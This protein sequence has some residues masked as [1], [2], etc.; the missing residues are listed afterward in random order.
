MER[1]LMVQHCSRKPLPMATK[2][3][4]L[5][6]ELDNLLTQYRKIELESL[7]EMATSLRENATDINDA[8]NEAENFVQILRNLAVEVHVTISNTPLLL[9]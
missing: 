7:V 8:L 3:T 9:C 5:T 1:Q 2:G 6:T 4:H